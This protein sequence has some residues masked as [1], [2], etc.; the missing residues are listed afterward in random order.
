ML[1]LLM[2]LASII[3]VYS[4]H[5]NHIGRPP[6]LLLLLTAM[7][8]TVCDHALY[9]RQARYH[10]THP[11]LL[12]FVDIPHFQ[13][14]LVSTDICIELLVCLTPHFL[15][16]G[17][18]DEALHHLSDEKSYGYLRCLCQISVELFCILGNDATACS[19]V[20]L[21]FQKLLA[22]SYLDTTSPFRNTFVHA[23]DKA[24]HDEPL[25]GGIEIFDDIHYPVQ[26]DDDQSD[27]FALCKFL[28]YI[29]IL[30]Q[31]SVR[32]V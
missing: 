10:S 4:K 1:L 22:Q 11:Y 13:Q 30:T 17:N 29:I 16:L 21:W 8:L 26:G 15:L 31:I 5:L 3:P 20:L 12:Q 18:S 14:F 9:Y 25:R 6:L 19:P 32:H 28:L 23:T 24:L 2:L 7:T 27:E